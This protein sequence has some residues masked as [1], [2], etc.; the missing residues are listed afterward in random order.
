MLTLSPSV[1][2]A[3][4]AHAQTDSQRVARLYQQAV[5]RL[6]ERDPQAAAASFRQ[7]LQIDSTHYNAWLGLGEIHMRIRRYAEARR[8]LHKAVEQNPD[9][10]EARYQL[11]QTYLK[12]GDDVFGEVPT[13]S[14][15]KQRARQM[16]EEIVTSIHTTHALYRNDAGGDFTDIARDVGLEDHRGGWGASGAD[17][18]NDGD[19]DLYVSRDAWEG[20]T[21]NSLYQARKKSCAT[22]GLSRMKF[23]MYP[24][25]P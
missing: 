13:Q 2:R 22:F 20:G 16:F 3:Q 11:G 8:F 6:T 24:S 23:D 14:S 18:D 9:R 17:Y 25:D 5:Q 7:L 10:V 4:T 15:H 19:L 21:P 12:G 1:C